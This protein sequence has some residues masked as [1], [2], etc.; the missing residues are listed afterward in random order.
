[1]HLQVVELR[2]E[3][4]EGYHVLELHNAK[5]LQVASTICQVELRLHSVNATLPHVTLENN[6]SNVDESCRLSISAWNSSLNVI[7]ARHVT[8]LNLTDSRVKRVHDGRLDALWLMRSSVEEMDK[9]E[10]AGQGAVWNNSLFLGP[11][12]V[13]LTAPLNSRNVQLLLGVV[14]YFPHNFLALYNDKNGSE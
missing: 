10:V 8:S 6:T 13:T 1:M 12:N 11:I 2:G 7:W 14:S 4:V 9:L 3:L 5:S